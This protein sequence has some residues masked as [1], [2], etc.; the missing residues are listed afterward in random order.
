M[1]GGLLDDLIKSIDGLPPD[2]RQEMAEAALMATDGM[3]WLPQIGPQTDAYFCD[4]DDL[5]YGGQAGGG[6][7]D[8][9]LGLAATAHHESL[10]LRRIT[11]DARKLCDRMEGILGHIQGRNLSPQISWKL[12]ERKIDFAGC[13]YEQDKQ[14][15]KGH[16]HDL[17][18]FDEVGDF[19]YSQFMFIKAWNRSA[20]P[21]Q[22][23][24]TVSA[25]N[26][27]TTP[28]GLWVIEYWAPWLDPNHPNPAKDGE[29][30]HFISDKNDKGHEV[31][32]KGKYAYDHDRGR[33]EQ[34]ADSAQ[35]QDYPAH[36][37]VLSSRSR[38]FIRARLAD[39]AYLRDTDYGATLDALPAEIRAAYRDGR[40]DQ[41]I[42]DNPWQIIPTAWIKAAQERWT[43]MPP[44][45]V[46]MC[47]MG[48]DP[49][50]GGDDNTVIACRYDG[51]YD[52][53][54]SVPG[55][56]TPLGS[57]VAALV[58]AKRKD[59]ALPIIDMGGGYGSGVVQA[60]QGNDIKH[61]A[62][63]GSEGVSTRTKDGK[64]KFKNKRTEAYWKFREALDPDQA[65]GSPIALP[66]NPRLVADLAAPTFLIKGIEIIAEPK[67]DIVDRLGRS[68]DDGDA[69]VMAWSDG[70][71]AVTHDTMW[72]SNSGRPQTVMGHQA[73]RR[74]R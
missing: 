45:G 32:V 1:S 6:K 57:D 3:P 47:A 42:K 12:G 52:Q 13:Q 33:F 4:A 65:G 54:L 67:V 35:Q 44:K 16:P 49:A 10:L 50:Q 20:R 8:L 74:R 68:P 41:S 43:A 27:P 70:A 73:Q 53:T 55:K 69:V 34:V 46:P 19:L 66:P 14:R 22:R 63:K 51:W 15:F 38:S 58:I 62:Y 9:L 48:V 59:R 64:L 25:G 60:L 26:P 17:I 72:K 31:P 40:F 5:F 28:E 36:I 23:C 29:I 37:E 61:Y 18:G 24:R 39:N 2:Q 11:G 30:R 71:K 7:T 56:L 21:G